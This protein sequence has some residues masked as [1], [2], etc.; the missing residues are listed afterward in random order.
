M[1][2]APDIIAIAGGA[3][4]RL[5]L[6]VSRRT[7]SP[8]PRPILAAIPREAWT[9]ITRQEHRPHEYQ[10]LIRTILWMGS[11]GHV[12]FR[13]VRPIAQASTQSVC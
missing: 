11:K 5:A 12:G 4:Q 1:N 7:L 13:P 2:L 3:Q 10:R 9:C 8:A 6:T